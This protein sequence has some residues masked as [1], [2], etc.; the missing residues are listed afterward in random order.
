MNTTTAIL[1]SEVSGGKLGTYT[2]NYAGHSLGGKLAQQLFIDSY[3]ERGTF[4][5]VRRSDLGRTVLFNAAPT[6][7]RG[8]DL[9]SIP[10][11]DYNIT[12]YITEGEVL[13]SVLPSVPNDP[14]Y[15]LGFLP[16]STHYGKKVYLP[17][18]REVN[19]AV[20]Q[21]LSITHLILLNIILMIM[22]IMIQNIFMVLMLMIILKDEQ[23]TILLSAEL[24][25]IS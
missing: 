1:K 10:Y 20:D 21:L 9:L 22:V 19:N 18:S 8:K 2:L 23:L 13:N 15:G 12:N 17:Y 5:D 16:F 24:V 3:E 6:Q 4:T 7:G 11:T 25:M 14:P